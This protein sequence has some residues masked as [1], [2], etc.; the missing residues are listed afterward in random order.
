MGWWQWCKAFA[1]RLTG[2][3]L[4]LVEIFRE[5]NVYVVSK[6]VV[7][8]KG[9][10]V[11]GERHVMYQIVPKPHPKQVTLESLKDYV[12]RLVMHHPEEGFKLARVGQYY[13]ITKDKTNSTKP[14]VPIYFDLRNQKFYVEKTSLKNPALT[15]YIIMRTLGALGVSQSK[16]VGGEMA[17]NEL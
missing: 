1:E 2:K 16:Y 8:G 17:K 13:V 14:N 6:Q 9:E 7:R 10:R 11:Y 5:Y 15:N 12:Q 4:R 3:K